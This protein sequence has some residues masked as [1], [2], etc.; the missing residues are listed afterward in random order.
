MNKDVLLIG[1][2]VG[3]LSLAIILAKSGFNVRVVE[4]NRLPGGMMRSYFRKGHECHVGI[5]YLGALGKGQL[6]NRFFDYLGIKVPVERMGLKGVIDRYIFDD[7]SFDLPEGIDAYEQNLRTVFPDE[8]EQIDG[9]M[10]HLK[11]IAEKMNSLDFLFGDQADFTEPEL[12]M[13]VEDYLNKLNCSSQLKGVLSVPSG[14]IGVPPCQCPVFYHNMALASYLLSSWRLKSHTQIADIFVNRLEELGGQVITGDGVENILIESKIT[15]G[16]RLNSGREL[17]A[18]AVVGAVHP[19][20][21]LDM[22]PDIAVRPLYRKRISQLKNTHSIFCLHAELDASAHPEIPYNIFK[23]AP[24]KNGQMPDVKYY[25]IRQSLKDKTTLSILTSGRSELWQ[26]WKKTS[27][28]RRGN[29]YVQAKEEFAWQLIS[30]SEKILGSL[31][32]CSLIDTYTPLSIRDWVNSPEG[33]AYGVLRSCDQLLS[34]AMLNRTSVKGMFLA[35]QSV[36]APGVIGTIM[37]SFHTA[38]FMMGNEM[39][40]KHYRK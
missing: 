19:R 26:K 28:G 1:S 31:K 3:G 27:T 21:I 7:F 11:P 13:P 36:M 10:K 40:K 18:P 37:G 9:I 24:D 4:K 14:W 35:G 32:G 39:F 17:F 15:K 30:E 6:L 2:G 25:Q 29:D 38:R 22:M 23:V 34:G 33:T 5:H 16:V 8:Q 12:F 20:I